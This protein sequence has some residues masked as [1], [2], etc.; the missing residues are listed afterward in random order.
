MKSATLAL[1]ALFAVGCGATVNS[2]LSPTANVGQ[3]RTFAFYSSPYKQ[4]K[5]E[6]LADQQIRAAITQSLTG[7][8]LHEATGG[9]P[10]FLIS[11]HVVEQQKL[12][13]NDIGYGYWGFGGV[14]LTTYT[15]GTLVVDFID[16]Q[17]HKVFWRGTAS[18]MVNDPQNPNQQKL[19]AAVV[20][21][22]NRYPYNVASASRPAM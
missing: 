20:K 11:Y 13:A 1:A 22:M 16:P 8:G 5:P 6:S 2:S 10:D 18:Q 4:G 21:L 19:E 9:A 7:K 12:E 14:D 17:T 3:Y 15:Q